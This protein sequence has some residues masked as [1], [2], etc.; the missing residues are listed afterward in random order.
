VGLSPLWPLIA[1][2]RRREKGERPRAIFQGCAFPRGLFSG[3]SP[4]AMA[5]EGRQP[6]PPF[7]ATP[8][9]VA[10]EGGCPGQK[11]VQTAEVR[12]AFDQSGR[13]ERRVKEVLNSN[14]TLPETA[15][16]AVG[17]FRVST[18]GQGT[19]GKGP[20]RPRSP[21]APLHQRRKPEG[22]NPRGSSG[23]KVPGAASN[24][25]QRRWGVFPK[26]S[27]VSF[28]PEGGPPQ[29]THFCR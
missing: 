13:R 20:A 27:R 8:S 26:A 9:G 25:G 6:G 5:A 14:G 15:A 11:R 21:P 4:S 3:G 18:P 19:L 29:S 17:R 10:R 28:P 24:G 2:G 1:L 22:K 12:R 7:S 16:A 23:G